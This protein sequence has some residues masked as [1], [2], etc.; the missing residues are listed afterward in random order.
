MAQQAVLVL[1]GFSDSNATYVI[2][3]L[4]AKIKVRLAHF[5]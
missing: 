5:L 2:N 1:I 3:S 4:T